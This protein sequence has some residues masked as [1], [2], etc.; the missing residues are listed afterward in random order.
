MAK[1]LVVFDISGTLLRKYHKAKKEHR[2]LASMGI[3]PDANFKS[4]LIYNRPHLDLLIKFLKTHNTSYVLWTTGMR[5][6][7]VH[8]VKHLEL[9]GFNR[10]LDW[11][12]QLDCK[13]GKVKIESECNLWVKDLNVVARNHGIGV[14][15]CILVDD[16][17]DKS[18]H[19]QNFICCPE[20][21]PGAE[22]DGIK[23]ICKHLDDFFEC[24][25]N[26]IAKKIEYRKKG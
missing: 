4:Y 22:D 15:R 11:Y 18:V 1:F 2:E 6:N 19:T 3:K 13:V 25:E 26:C 9:V 8:L 7:A 21:T 12:S 10:F 17:V 23:F 16:S 20:F 14:E 24:K 5:Q